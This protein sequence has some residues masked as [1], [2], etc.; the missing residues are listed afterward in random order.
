MWLKLVVKNLFLILRCGVFFL[1]QLDLS[2]TERL[3]DILL[4]VIGKLDLA[5]PFSVN[6][7][8]VV[9]NCCKVQSL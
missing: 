4:Y 7:S 5:G 6:N 2:L 8:S 9:A 3:L 1:L